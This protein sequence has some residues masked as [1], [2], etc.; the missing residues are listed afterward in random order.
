MTALTLP[1]GALAELRLRLSDE[2]R[3]IT[4]VG[5]VVQSSTRAEGGC[6]AALRTIEIC[7][8]DRRRLVA[9][10]AELSG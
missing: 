3:E 4:L 10:L 6:E 9:A 5:R 8:H 2:G 7:A 1:E